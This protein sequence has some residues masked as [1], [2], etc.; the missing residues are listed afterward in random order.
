MINPNQQLK[1]R[2]RREQFADLLHDMFQLNRPA[3]KGSKPG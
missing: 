2:Q 1:A 3:R